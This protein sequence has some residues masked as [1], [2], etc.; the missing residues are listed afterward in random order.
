VKHVPVNI[1]SGRLE[2][3]IGKNTFMLRR[4]KKRVDF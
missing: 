2:E 3:N 1:I 4:D